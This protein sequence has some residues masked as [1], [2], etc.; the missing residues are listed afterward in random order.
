MSDVNTEGKVTLWNIPVNKSVLGR[1]NGSYYFFFFFSTMI[2]HMLSYS[3]LLLSIAMAFSLSIVIVRR[4]VECCSCSNRNRGKKVLLRENNVYDNSAR[5]MRA[6][7]LSGAHLPLDQSHP[8]LSLS[9]FLCILS[10]GLL[11]PHPAFL[12]SPT[13]PRSS[14]YGSTM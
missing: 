6:G 13:I 10:F 4:L 14:H 8:L 7:N 3:K 2:K 9:L 11:P 1:G 12:H 5:I